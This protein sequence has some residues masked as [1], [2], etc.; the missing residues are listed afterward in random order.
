V[1]AA[2]ARRIIRITR[3][4]VEN[5]SID[6]RMQKMWG[7]THHD[8]LMGYLADI[9]QAADK[10]AEAQYEAGRAEQPLFGSRD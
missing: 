2:D 8:R 1:T 10:L 3:G 4:L 5:L 9:E 7:G 6:A